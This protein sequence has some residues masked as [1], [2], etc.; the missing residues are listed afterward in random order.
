[1]TGACYRV[2]NSKSPLVP[3]N[4]TEQIPT[5]ICTG[6]LTDTFH[7]YAI[8][9]YIYAPGVHVGGDSSL[10]SNS[11][12]LF[13]YLKLYSVLQCTHRSRQDG[14]LLVLYRFYH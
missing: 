13:V 9:L 2:K 11:H 1:M 4:M 6:T 12:V 8:L 7:I 3:N 10:C 14:L 5:N